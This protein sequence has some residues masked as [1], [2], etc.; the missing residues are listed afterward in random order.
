MPLEVRELIIKTT[1]DSGS[2]ANNAGE[3]GEEGMRKLRK[4][5]LKECK[6]M[7]QNEVKK[8]SDR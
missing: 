7:I 3:L 6:T 4:R 1:V 8:N 5:I 2:Q